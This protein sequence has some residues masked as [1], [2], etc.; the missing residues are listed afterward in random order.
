MEWLKVRK[1]WQKDT[2]LLHHS[3][4][5]RNIISFLFEF[6]SFHLLS[7]VFGSF[8]K[9]LLSV[10]TNKFKYH[11]T[12]TKDVSLP[13]LSFMGWEGF[14]IQKAN[15]TQLIFT[16]ESQNCPQWCLNCCFADYLLL[17]LFFVFPSVESY[18]C[19]WDCVFTSVY[20]SSPI[21]YKLQMNHLR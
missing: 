1:R 20:T 9:A 21:Q 19:E 4:S 15:E 14:V 13:G 2:P 6:C 18:R 12:L 7:H 16:E 17:S 5:E 3:Q 11:R 8:F 10:L